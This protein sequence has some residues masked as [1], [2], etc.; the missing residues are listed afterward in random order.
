MCLV[1]PPDGNQPA[2]LQPAAHSLPRTAVAT[3]T[4]CSQRTVSCGTK[5]GNY[6]T[7]IK[8][9]CNE[10]KFKTVNISFVH[11][12]RQCYYSPIA[13]LRHLSVQAVWLRQDLRVLR[14]RACLKQL[15]LFLNTQSDSIMYKTPT[16]ALFYLT[17]Y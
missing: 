11:A 2:S 17:L 6:V 16:H 3:V 13:V 1:L 12:I 8:L 10:A 9:C 14:Y 7:S 5:K 4:V 15:H